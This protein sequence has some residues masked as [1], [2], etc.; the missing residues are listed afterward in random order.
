MYFH[1]YHHLSNSSGV[2]YELVKALQLVLNTTVQSR[3]GGVGLQV[4]LHTAIHNRESGVGLQLPLQFYQAE[5]KRQR[6]ASPLTEAF[7]KDWVES[8]STSPAWS[9]KDECSQSSGKPKKDDPVAGESINV[10][11]LVKSK[12]LFLCI[13]TAVNSCE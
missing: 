12:L 7:L 4:I 8:R 10:L 2:L 3:E 13:D 1:E 6:S 5:Q 11:P 9:V